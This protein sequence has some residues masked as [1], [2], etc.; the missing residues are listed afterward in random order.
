MNGVV[1]I[2][3]N[4]IPS[5]CFLTTSQEVAS[6]SLRT[7]HPLH[8]LT[9]G[10]A[11]LPRRP[12][13]QLFPA[14][15]LSPDDAHSLWNRLTLLD[16]ECCISNSFAYVNESIGRVPLSASI[17]SS[18]ALSIA[19]S[20]ISGERESTSSSLG[21]AELLSGS[22]TKVFLCTFPCRRNFCSSWLERPAVIQTGR[23]L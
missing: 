12:P 1:W 8:F 9:T 10:D 7:P 23:I 5:I 16:T 21:G 15:Q 19:F 2:A 11:S 3:L 6:E 17:T 14:L 4:S 22:T 20:K 18:T 13:R